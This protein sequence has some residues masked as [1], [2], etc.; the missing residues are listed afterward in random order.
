MVTLCASS[1]GACWDVRLVTGLEAVS[2]GEGAPAEPDHCPAWQLSRGMPV[3][4]SGSIPAVEGAEAI[5]Q[6]LAK[7][8]HQSLGAQCARLHQGLLP[9]HPC[10]SFQGPIPSQS[11]PS[12]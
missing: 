5:P 3:V 6:G 9:T 7:E 4:S 10:P 12:L 8:A 1:L 11:V 2:R